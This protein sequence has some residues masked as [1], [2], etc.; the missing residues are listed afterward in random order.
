MGYGLGR[1]PPPPFHFR[2]RQEEHYYNHYTYRKHGARSASSTNND[3]R[4]NSYM[5]SNPPPQSYDRYM[6]SCM[7]RTDLQPAENHPPTNKPAAAATALTPSAPDTVTGSNSTAVGNSSTS[8]PSAPRPLNESVPP[9]PQILNKTASDED[10]DTVSIAE[11]GYPALI[12]QQKVRKCLELYMGYA[13]SYRSSTGGVQGLHRCSSG[14]L[15]VVTTCTVLVL[16]NS[17][18]QVL[19]LHRDPY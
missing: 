6:D 12:K 7:E 8:V 15:V 11:I 17:S 3:I 13:E 14:L 18:V 10:D 4:D 19:L 1:V 9:T 16:L 2:S 5:Y